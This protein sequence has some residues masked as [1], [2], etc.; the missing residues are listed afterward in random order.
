MTDVLNGHHDR[1]LD[2][3]DDQHDHYDHGDDD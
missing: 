3:G 1:L 2:N